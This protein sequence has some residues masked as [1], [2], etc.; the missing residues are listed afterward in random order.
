MTDNA[1]EMSRIA[2]GTLNLK[3]LITTATDVFIIFFTEN[4]VCISCESSAL[5]T[6]CMK[7]QPIFIFSEKY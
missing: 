4:K 6:I 1:F 5:Q 3:V 2:T 7:Y